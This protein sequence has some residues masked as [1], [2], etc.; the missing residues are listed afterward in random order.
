M[1]LRELTEQRKIALTRQDEPHIARH[2][3]HN[4]R[5]NR[6]PFTLHDSA[7][8]IRIIVWHGDCICCRPLCHA[9]RT[10]YTERSHPGT[11]ANEQTVAVSMIAADKFHDL[12][13]SRIAACEAKRTHCRLRPGV[14]HADDLNGGIYALYQLCEIR[15][16]KCRCPVACP[17][18]HSFLQRLHDLRMCMADDHWSP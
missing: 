7:N 4:D 14:H 1:L 11:C 8:G 3:F 18:C 6:V 9:R 5:C 12:V 15:F 10:R 13:T 17:A 2:R 16:P